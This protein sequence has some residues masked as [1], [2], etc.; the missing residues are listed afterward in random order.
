M[1]ASVLDTL[2]PK[3]DIQMTAE[4]EKAAAPAPKSAPAPAPAPEA[5]SKPDEESNPSVPANAEDAAASEP[6]PPTPPT[7]PSRLDAILANLMAGH[8]SKV[9]KLVFEAIRLQ[10]KM[11]ST[12]LSFD[13]VPYLGRAGDR[14]DRGQVELSDKVTNWQLKQFLVPG[15]TDFKHGDVFDMLLSPTAMGLSAAKG[16]PRSAQAGMERQFKI[17]VRAK[18]IVGRLT[19]FK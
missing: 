14:P 13:Y 9:I 6:S 8:S 18:A 5:P 19:F 7:P 12:Y 3:E 1:L 4:P 15:Q 17:V 2:L 10:D 16:V 11:R